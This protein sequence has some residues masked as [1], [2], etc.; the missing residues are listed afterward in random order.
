M[1]HDSYATWNRKCQK[2]IRLD[3]HWRSKDC[4]S[5]PYQTCLFFIRFDDIPR[6]FSRQ[7]QCVVTAKSQHHPWGDLANIS[8]TEKLFDY[9]HWLIDKPKRYRSLD[10]FGTLGYPWMTGRC[11]RATIQWII[12]DIDHDSFL[13][14]NQ[15]VFLR[16]HVVLTI[17]TVDFL[18]KNGKFRG[19]INEY[20][21]ILFRVS[22][23]LLDMERVMVT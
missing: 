7:T 2:A 17:D 15:R 3:I 14:V 5:S 13:I 19:I 16:W 18:R 21:Q 10:L 4:E 12:V 9:N 20:I 23:T 11:R 22:L 1:C 8:I 6:F